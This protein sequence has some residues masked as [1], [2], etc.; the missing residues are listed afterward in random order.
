MFDLLWPNIPQEK[1]WTRIIFILIV[2]VIG[3]GLFN[4][5]SFLVSMRSGE[6]SDF[7]VHSA[8]DFI[9]FAFN[10]P[11]VIGSY[12]FFGASIKRRNIFGII[13]ALGFLL[14]SLSHAQY[15]F[16]SN[17]LDYLF[18]VLALLFFNMGLNTHTRL[19]D[20]REVIFDG[21][22][23]G[24]VAHF[25]TSIAGATQGCLLSGVLFHFI[26]DLIP[27]SVIAWVSFFISFLAGVVFSHLGGRLLENL[28]TEKVAGSI[29]GFIGGLISGLTGLMIGGIM[30]GIAGLFLVAFPWM[31]LFHGSTT[32]MHMVSYLLVPIGAIWGFKMAVSLGIGPGR[33]IGK[34]GYGSGDAKVYGGIFLGGFKGG[35]SGSFGGGASG[36]AGSSGSW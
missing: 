26:P 6:M 14:L 25:L 5:L 34:T 29:G 22:K 13:F 15:G 12:Y 28:V 8:D 19:G 35:G 10:L 18:N 2:S 3:I 20:K 1:K 33:R 23:Q 17:G 32:G 9:D 11:F 21:L 7:L 30:G 4:L 27:P 36:G 31:F 24:F 16:G